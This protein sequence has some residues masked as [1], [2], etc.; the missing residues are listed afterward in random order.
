VLTPP[1][2][3]RVGIET[4]VCGEQ[5]YGAVCIRKGA[6][7]ERTRALEKASVFDRLLVSGPLQGE[8]GE[9]FSLTKPPSGND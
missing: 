9:E 6:R 5:T 3:T 8:V 2:K 1:E 7:S 4:L